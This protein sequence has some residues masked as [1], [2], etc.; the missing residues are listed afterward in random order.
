KG[1]WAGVDFTRQQMREIRYAALLHDFGKVGVREQVLV[2][3]KKLPPHLWERVDARFR[4]IR[5]TF[6]AEML[7]RKT[8]LLESYGPGGS[9]PMIAELESEYEARVAELERF[10]QAIHDANEPRVLPEESEA[11]LEVIARRQ[12][13]GLDGQP[14]AFITDEELHFLSIPKGSLDERE[15]KEIESHVSQTYSFLT[16]IP[17][18]EDLRNVARIAYG[19]HEKLDGGGYPRGIA[20]ED[21]PVQTRIMTIA[22]IF[23]ALTASDRPYKRALPAERALDIISMEAREGMLDTD[24]VD[25]MVES[26]AYEKVLQVDW[27]NL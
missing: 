22:D 6:E 26:R 3:A 18:T 16:Q 25:L 23:D 14:L 12:F 8:E 10:E 7:R 13:P 9:I 27:K 11:I 15:R 1:R 21:I 20:D 17:W 24:L 19:H 2:K 5:R 4:L